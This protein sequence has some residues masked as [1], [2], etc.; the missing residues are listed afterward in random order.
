LNFNSKHS[1]V[2]HIASGIAL[3]STVN[4][5]SSQLQGISVMLSEYVLNVVEFLV[6]L[7]N[8]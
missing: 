1:V 6:A 7:G 8:A 3:R 2:Q 5:I 4:L